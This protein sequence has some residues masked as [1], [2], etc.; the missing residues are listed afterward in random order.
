MLLA[1]LPARLP[2]LKALPAIFDAWLNLSHLEKARVLVIVRTSAIATGEIRL[3]TLSCSPSLYLDKQGG[4]Y[5][6]TSGNQINLNVKTATSTSRAH[7]TGWVYM[8]IQKKRLSVGLMVLVPGSLLSNTQCESPV[9]G[10]T[11]FHQRSP[12]SRR[13]AMFLR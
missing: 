1:R 11:S 5:S 12:T 10:S 8:A 13:P 6:P 9:A 7:S 4:K 2:P 3:V